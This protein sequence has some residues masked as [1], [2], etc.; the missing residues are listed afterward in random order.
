MGTKIGTGIRTRIG[1]GIKTGI[2]NGIGTEIRT[3][4][5]E[6]KGKLF[7]PV[8]QESRALCWPKNCSWRQKK[9]W[10]KEWIPTPKYLVMYDDVVNKIFW[11]IPPRWKG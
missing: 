2:R 7:H 10:Q 3:Q 9:L 5:R 6:K 1:T 11:Y 8:F 4:K